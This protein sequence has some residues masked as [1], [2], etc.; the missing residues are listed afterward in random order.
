[1]ESQI[2]DNS[3]YCSYEIWYCGENIIWLLL[4]HLWMKNKI[5]TCIKCADTNLEYTLPTYTLFNCS[6]LCFCA[7]NILKWYVILW[8]TFCTLCTNRTLDEDWNYISLEVYFIVSLH[9]QIIQ[10]LYFCQAC[11]AFSK[12]FWII[13]NKVIIEFKRM[14]LHISYNYVY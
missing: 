10:I 14:S 3:C 5:C 6:E 9:Q 7:I 4:P 8:A 1:M 11:L 12:I 13:C 2:P